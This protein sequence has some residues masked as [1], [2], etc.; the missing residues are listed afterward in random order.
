MAPEDRWRRTGGCLAVITRHAPSDET[1]PSLP[2]VPKEWKRVL[3]ILRYQRGNRTRVRLLV[4]GMV[5]RIGVPMIPRFSGRAE[6]RRPEGPWEPSPGLSALA[7]NPGAQVVEVSALKVAQEN[8]TDI[9]FGSKRLL[10]PF[11]PP[12]H[13]TMPTQGFVRCGG[14]NP[15]LVSCGPSGRPATGTR[16]FVG[17][18]TPSSHPQVEARA[19]ERGLYSDDNRLVRYRP[20]WRKRDI[21]L[22]PYGLCSLPRGNQIP[23]Y[24]SGWGT[25]V[26]FT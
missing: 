8:S 14:L 7:D 22:R 24:P 11:R 15:G 13:G 2:D 10:R 1:T 21:P 18:G 4:K 20:S 6:K 17:D 12:T 19:D 16:P 3:R 5:Q 9:M 26:V 23:P 25:D